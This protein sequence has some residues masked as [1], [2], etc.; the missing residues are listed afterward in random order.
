MEGQVPEHTPKSKIGDKLNEVLGRS[1]IVKLM[2]HGVFT[3]PAP[4]P[5]GF[6]NLIFLHSSLH[7][8]YPSIEF[9][10]IPVRYDPEAY[11]NYLGFSDDQSRTIFENCKSEAKQ[12]SDINSA[13][14]LKCVNDQMLK[15]YRNSMWDT[16]YDGSLLSKVR[17]LKSRD[18]PK[19][20]KGSRSFQVGS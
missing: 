10:K 14:M 18:D 7:L 13:T 16:T 20:M 4:D 3:N 11:L 8:P 19:I 17:W 15:H 2:I 5:L 9:A 12:A 1:A 6:H